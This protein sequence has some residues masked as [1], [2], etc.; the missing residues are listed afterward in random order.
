MW[1]PWLRHEDD[2]AACPVNGALQLQCLV[3]Q[4]GD[5]EPLREKLT[6]DSDVLEN[7]QQMPSIVATSKWVPNRDQQTQSPGW[8]FCFLHS[9]L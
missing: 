9:Y 1:M 6:G 8:L 7:D 4:I 5:F 3:V 2:G